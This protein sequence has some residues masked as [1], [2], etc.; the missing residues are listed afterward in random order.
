ME[1]N[2]I[3]AEIKDAL[4]EYVSNKGFDVS[5]KEVVVTLTAGR[6]AKGHSARIEIIPEGMEIEEVPVKK[7]KVPKDDDDDVPAINFGGND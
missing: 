7:Q 3:Q 1:I 4:I 6:G 2:L 5:G